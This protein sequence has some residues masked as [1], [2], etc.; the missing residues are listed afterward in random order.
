[1]KLAAAH[2]LAN[3]VEDPKEE[4]ILPNAFNQ[5]VVGAVAHAVMQS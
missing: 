4:M 1:M 3:L 2:A 5:R